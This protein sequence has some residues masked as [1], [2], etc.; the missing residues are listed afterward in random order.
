[1][2]SEFCGNAAAFPLPNLE[3]NREFVQVL[4]SS[5]KLKSKF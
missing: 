2:L 1:M 3:V 4:K 5:R